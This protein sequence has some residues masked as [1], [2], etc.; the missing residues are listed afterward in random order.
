MNELIDNIEQTK[1]CTK[2]EIRKPFKDFSAHPMCKNG[3]LSYCRLCDSKARKAW[4][5]RNK[6]YIAKQKRVY[7]LKKRYGIDLEFYEYLIKKQN[8]KCAIC[9]N[10]LG[11]NDGHRL[12][13]DHCHATGK[14]RGLLCKICNNAIGLF[15]ENI[16]F[17]ERT[18]SYLKNG[19]I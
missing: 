19:G 17:L 5:L 9:E 2:C 3:L 13:V 7:N 18:I 6:E 15:R 11:T 12:A 10:V 16:T 14:V 1:K 4:E 8:N